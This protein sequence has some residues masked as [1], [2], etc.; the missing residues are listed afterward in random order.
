M[1]ALKIDTDK[2]FRPRGP[3]F[4][5]PQRRLVVFHPFAGVMKKVNYSFR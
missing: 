3:G 1:L 5:C 2:E 4:D